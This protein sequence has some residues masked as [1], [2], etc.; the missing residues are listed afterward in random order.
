[1][2]KNAGP[3]QD[4]A[5]EWKASQWQTLFQKQ[6]CQLEPLKGQFKVHLYKPCGFQVPNGVRFGSHTTYYT[7]ISSR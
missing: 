7:G 5:T 2:G 3:P 1:M 6:V 4:T